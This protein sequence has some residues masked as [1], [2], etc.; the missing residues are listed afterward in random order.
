MTAARLGLTLLSLA[1]RVCDPESI[2]IVVLPIVADL[3]FEAQINAHRSPVARTWIRAS[4]Y[5][6]FFKAIA[7]TVMLGRG[8]NP[9]KSQTL[10]W[11]R[12]LLA[13]PAA[14][15][16]TALVQ[17]ATMLLFS[18][19]IV[20]RAEGSPYLEGVN[21]VKVFCSPFMS[22]AL[23]WTLYLVAP[24]H[25]RSPVAVA[26]LIVIGL[27]GGLMVFGSLMAW[28]QFHNWLFGIGLALWLG[29]GL[30]YWLARRFQPPTGQVA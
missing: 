19:V 23:F 21:T 8:R 12:L 9:M 14:L 5:A 20:H 15:L 6:G 4:G 30:S 11:L 1:K 26:A 27:W 29:G 17:L 10:G 3:Q 13:I 25:R 7:L 24:T 22:A 16:V 18:M 28:P 2:D